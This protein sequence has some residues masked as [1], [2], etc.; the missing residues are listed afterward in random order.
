MVFM[1][2]SMAG[3]RFV[4]VDMEVSISIPMPLSLGTPRMSSRSVGSKDAME[5]FENARSTPD[6]GGLSGI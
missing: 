5:V 3:R 4:A 2:P 6:S 1:L